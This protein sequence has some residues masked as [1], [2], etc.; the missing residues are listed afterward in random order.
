MPRPII[1]LNSIIEFIL[2]SNTINLQV[3]ASTPVVINF[4]VVTIVGYFSLGSMK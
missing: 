3:L 1:C 4:D 2:F